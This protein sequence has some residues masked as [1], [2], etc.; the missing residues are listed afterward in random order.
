MIQLT[1]LALPSSGKYSAISVMA[2]GWI[3]AIPIP[4]NGY[5][6]SIMRVVLEEHVPDVGFW[7]IKGLG[8]SYSL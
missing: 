3:I 2:M 4:V 8:E 6:R 7:P 5:N 1:A